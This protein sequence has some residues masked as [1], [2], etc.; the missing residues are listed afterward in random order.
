MGGQNQDFRNFT[1]GVALLVRNHLDLLFNSTVSAPATAHPDP[2]I[3]ADIP[4]LWSPRRDCDDVTASLRQTKREFSQAIGTRSA[5]RSLQGLIDPLAVFPLIALKLGPE[6]SLDRLQIVVFQ[7]DGI[8]RHRAR[9]NHILIGR[10]HSHV[11]SM[12]RHNQTVACNFAIPLVHH[13]GFNPKQVVVGGNRRRQCDRELALIIEPRLFLLTLLAASAP[14]L[15][16][17]VGGLIEFIVAI[18]P[19]WIIGPSTNR[20]SNFGSLNRLPEEILRLDNCFDAFPLHDSRLSYPDFYFVLR[21]LILLNIESSVALHCAGTQLQ[22]VIPQPSSNR[23]IKLSLDSAKTRQCQLLAKN[24]FA[25]VVGDLGTNGAHLWQVIAKGRRLTQDS[26]EIHLV[27]RP[28]NGPICIDV[29]HDAALFVRLKHI[30]IQRVKRHILTPTCDDKYVARIL[31]TKLGK[32]IG[33]RLVRTMHLLGGS[34]F[35]IDTLQASPTYAI[36]N[37]RQSLT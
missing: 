12:C 28:V 36:N 8:R 20:V 26:L 21:L 7:I 19:G 14:S 27:S 6:I 16:I 4:A 15:V 5:T 31:T 24:R 18:E 17:P 32:A 3:V 25:L 9:L 10:H 23:H 2:G 11:T 1:R 30:L 37:P 13:L 29:G 34:K 35:H 33:I 22:A